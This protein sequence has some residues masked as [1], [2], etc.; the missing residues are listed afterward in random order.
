MPNSIR[1]IT[2]SEAINQ[3]FIRL[4]RKAV[5]EV[6]PAAQTLGGLL[7][8]TDRETFCSLAKIASEARIP[9]ETLRNHMPKLHE[10]GYV[11]LLGREKT[12][13]GRA[14]RTVTIRITKKAKDESRDYFPLLWWSAAMLRN[15]W[16]SRLLWAFVVKSA[17]GLRKAAK[18][19]T[20]DDVGDLA[21]HVENLGGDDRF[22]FS[23]NNIGRETGL[24]RETIISAKRNLWRQKIIDWSG[25]SDGLS[26]DVITPNWNSQLMIT[27]TGNGMCTLAIKPPKTG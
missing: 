12:R 15:S 5:L 13:S 25:Q 18:A 4:P 3:R 20:D 21:E 23:L 9:M 14:R 6:G 16:S 1:V 26:T 17:L 11:E 10:A 8:L 27:D 19:A 7:M 24:T 2:M 22:Q